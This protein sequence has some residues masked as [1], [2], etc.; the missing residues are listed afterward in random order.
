MA[1]VSNQV[2]RPTAVSKRRL[3]ALWF[4]GSGVLFFLVLIQTT[5]NHYGNKNV[6]VF[7]WLL[8]TVL[9]SLS[10]VIGTLLLDWL[11]G[12]H[13]VPPVSSFIFKLTFWLSAAYLLAVLCL[14]VLQPFSSLEQIQILQQSNIWLGPFQGVVAG[15]MGAFFSSAAHDSAIPGQVAGE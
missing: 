7:T 4:A 13:S 9:P 2:Y 6:E 1:I 11:N 15:G 14:F 12:P 10:L 8:P 5:L 3:A